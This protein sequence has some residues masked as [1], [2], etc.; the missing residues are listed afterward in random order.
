MI[1]ITI[2]GGIIHIPIEATTIS[3]II[4]ITAKD[5]G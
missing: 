2:R 1:P 3:P 5:S 4:P